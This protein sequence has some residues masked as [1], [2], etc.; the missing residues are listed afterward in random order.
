VSSANSVVT[1][2]VP[3]TIRA[4]AEGLDPRRLVGEGE[5]AESD[6][7][8][9]LDGEVD[10]VEDRQVRV[11]FGPVVAEVQDERGDQEQ[12]QP[13]RHGNA[14]RPIGDAQHRAQRAPARGADARAEV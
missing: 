8:D 4:D 7:G 3:A 13:E 11:V 12:H 14:Q 1:S 6:R 2:V 10:R 9:R 5:V